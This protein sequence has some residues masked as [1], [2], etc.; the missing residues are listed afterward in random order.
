MAIRCG[1]NS[2]G[3][4]PI[5][6]IVI[7]KVR[8]TG[9]IRPN[10]SLFCRE[11]VTALISG[12]LLPPSWGA[13]LHLRR[14]QA[15]R[16][17]R[18]VA[19]ILVVV[20]SRLGLLRIALL[21]ISGLLIRL[22]RQAVRL[23]Q[24]CFNL[25]ILFLSQLVCAGLKDQ[26]SLLSGIG[27]GVKLGNKVTIAFEQASCHGPELCVA[28][29]SGKDFLVG[30]VRVFYDLSVGGRLLRHPSF[31]FDHESRLLAQHRLNLVRRC[32]NAPQVLFGKFRILAR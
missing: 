13:V 9:G 32:A 19:A 11:D 16:V 12:R 8:T 23:W 1:K 4:K 20:L 21:A 3:N 22:D 25:L 10:R 14:V 27:L 28:D 26:F 24:L 2:R 15:L 30:Q 6:F 5:V 18:A 17:S 7:G 31:Q 29:E